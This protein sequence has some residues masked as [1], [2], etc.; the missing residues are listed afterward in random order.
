M[1]EIGGVPPG[2]MAPSAP[3]ATKEA[4]G[5]DDFMKLLMAQIQNQDPLKPMDGQEFSSQLAQFS[6][7]EQLHNIG[8]GIDTLHAG[9]GEG[10]KMQALNMIGRRIQASGNEVDLVTGQSVVLNNS[11]PEGVQPTKATII[12]SG[13][14]VI[15]ELTFSERDG[16]AITWD[17]KDQDGVASPSGKYSVRLYGVNSSGQAQTASGDVSGVVTGVELEGKNAMLL[18]ETASGAKS[19]IAMSKVTQVSVD[20]SAAGATKPVGNSISAKAKAPEKLEVPD[21]EARAENEPQTESEIP[22]LERPIEGSG[23]VSESEGEG[24]MMPSNFADRAEYLASQATR[25][26]M[27]T[28]KP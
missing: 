17:G 15:R 8:Q 19:R 28:L 24:E 20:G 23:S 2:M 5:K 9:L 3:P 6:S 16:K 13:G 4:M 12:D 11:L 1:N 26:P 25:L 27:E 22:T 14:K 7:L 18:I 21:A 10:T